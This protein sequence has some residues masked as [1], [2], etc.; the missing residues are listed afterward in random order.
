MHINVFFLSFFSI[1]EKLENSSREICALGKPI[2]RRI[3]IVR[4]FFASLAFNRRW[5][6]RKWSHLSGKYFH[7]YWLNLRLRPL[8]CMSHFY[9]TVNDQ[10]LVK[11]EVR[12]SGKVKLE[13]ISFLCVFLNH[14]FVFI[15]RTIGGRERLPKTSL[16]HLLNG[17]HH[18]CVV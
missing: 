6:R 17:F 14:C 12:L 2:W 3:I 15:S 11:D 9:W 4:F 8:S 7:R 10:V 18:Q 5:K 13:S 16:E 1:Q